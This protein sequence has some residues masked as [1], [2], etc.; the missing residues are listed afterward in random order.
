MSPERKPRNLSE[1]VFRLVEYIRWV[2]RGLPPELFDD[3]MAFRAS[4]RKVKSGEIQDANEI[5]RIKN[6]GRELSKKLYEH[7][8]GSS[9]YASEKP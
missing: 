6:E 3:H 5:E 8:F 9:D 7:A 2:G 4:L 1:K